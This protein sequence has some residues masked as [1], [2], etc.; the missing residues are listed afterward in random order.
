MKNIHNIRTNYNLKELRRSGLEKTP[1]LQFLKWFNDLEEEADF[2]AVTLSTYSKQDG[3]H[4]RVVLLKDVNEKGFVF[5]TNYD[6]L[7]SRQIES[8]NHVALCFFWTKFQRQVRV[9][10]LAKKISKKTSNNYFI[11]RPRKSQISTWVSQQSDIVVNRSYLEQKFQEVEKKFQN[12]NIVKPDNWGGYQVLP[13]SV[14]F[15]QGRENRMHDRFVYK[16]KNQK[17]VV[18]RLFP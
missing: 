16:K 12:K 14:E 6:S 13:L 2:N 4:S 5:Y 8:N 17:W 10:G 7:K 9:N 1:I 18:N 15:W 3:V 11:E